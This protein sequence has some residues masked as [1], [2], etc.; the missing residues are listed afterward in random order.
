MPPRNSTGAI[1][2][3][4]F[5][6]VQLHAL[7]VLCEVHQVLF[8]DMEKVFSCPGNGVSSHLQCPRYDTV[9]IQEN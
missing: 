3:F 8:L 5:S 9:H 2:A 7:G 4:I 6:L 1:C